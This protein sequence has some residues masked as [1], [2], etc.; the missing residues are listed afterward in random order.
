MPTVQ[1]GSAAV[2]TAKDKY[3][4][5]IQTVLLSTDGS[6]ST[7]QKAAALQLATDGLNTVLAAMK[8]MEK[9]ETYQ[10]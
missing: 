6:M 1:E 7:G 8:A 4:Q 2:Q 10:F 5:D 9:A 3:F